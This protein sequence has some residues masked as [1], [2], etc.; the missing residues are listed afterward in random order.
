ML[1]AFL[2]WPAVAAAFAFAA[3]TA[4]PATSADSY[5]TRFR[6]VWAADACVQHRGQSWDDY[7]G[8][9]VR[10]Y[11]DRNGWD[12]TSTAVAAKI[13][14]PAVRARDMGALDELGARVAG[15]WAKDNACRKIRTTT[16]IFNIGERGKPAI[17]TWRAE[18]LAAAGADPGDG[19]RIRAAVARITGEVDAVLGP[20]K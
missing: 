6:S 4:S 18:L 3:S 12:A 7:R 15:E 14:D 17:S 8:W 9:L 20:A 10:F 19:S 2:G 5:A 11:T 13:A 1:F 16:G